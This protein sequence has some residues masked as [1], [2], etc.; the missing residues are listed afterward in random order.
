MVWRPPKRLGLLVAL[1]ALSMLAAIALFVMYSLIGQ[2][3]GPGFFLRIVWLICN[4][5]L[6]AVG[7]R[8]TV[9]LVGLRYQLDRDALTIHCG[10]HKHIVP[11]RDIERMAPATTFQGPDEFEG[12]HWPGYWRGRIHVDGMRNIRVY[13]TKPPE[14][15]LIAITDGGGYAISPQNAEEFLSDYAVRRDMGPLHPVAEHVEHGPTA[16]WPVWCDS[17]FWGIFAAGSLVCLVLSG[18]LMWRYPGLPTRL[19]LRLPSRGSLGRVASKGHLLVIPALGVAI[20]VANAC[21]GILLHR[22]ERLGAYLLIMAA[23]SIQL[24]FTVALVGIL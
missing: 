2:S 16:Q 3:I 6:L 24:L 12:L 13:A 4:A 17:L 23:L 21:L 19:I 22:Q 1:L 15:L 5:A 9:G 8:W 7:I 20:L 14:Q 18:Y 11:L 10:T